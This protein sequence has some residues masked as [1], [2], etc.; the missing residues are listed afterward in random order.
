MSDNASEN[1]TDLHRAVAG[2]GRSGEGADATADE[3]QTATDELEARAADDFYH[4]RP[5]EDAA[6]VFDPGRDGRP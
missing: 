2:P 6:H 3:A 5:L 1:V 4:D